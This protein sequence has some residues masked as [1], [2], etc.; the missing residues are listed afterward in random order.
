[1]FVIVPN[2][3]R[4]MD[5]KIISL[6]ALVAGSEFVH[7]QDNNGIFVAEFSLVGM[8]IIVL[9]CL[10]GIYLCLYFTCCHEY[11]CTVEDNVGCCGDLTN[12]E[13]KQH[14]QDDGN[15]KTDSSQIVPV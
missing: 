13:L 7:G 15:V 3:T 6:L 8:L 12:G 2:T 10:G 1:M 9:F 4:K 14:G 11:L 5:W